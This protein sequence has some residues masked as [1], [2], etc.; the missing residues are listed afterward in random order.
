MEAAFSSL[1][2]CT[3]DESTP[4]QSREVYPAKQIREESS[5]D[6]NQSHYEGIQSMI[7]GSAKGRPP[8]IGLYVRNLVLIMYA[9]PSTSGEIGGRVW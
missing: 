2:A 8:C 9:A 6:C 1:G 4:F 7:T 3:A 5:E